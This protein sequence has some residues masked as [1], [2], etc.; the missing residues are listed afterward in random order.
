MARFASRHLV[1]AGLLVMGAVAFADAPVPAQ[2]EVVK[3][4]A[5]LLSQGDHLAIRE[6]L[7]PE[8]VFAV[9]DL[10]WSVA[11]G[12]AVSAQVRAMV[13]AGVRLEVELEAFA[14]DGTVLV[15]RERMWG[16]EV[17]ESLAPLRSTG[18]YVMDGEQIL[19]IT[20]VLDGDQ[21]DVLMREAIIGRWTGLRAFRFD[22]D[23]T[24]LSSTTV[25]TLDDA[26]DDVGHFVIEG[27]VMT[28]VS[29][30]ASDICDPG[31]VGTWRLRFDSADRLT[32]IAVEDTC[33]RRAMGPGT[34]LLIRA[35]D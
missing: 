31:D 16:D 20:R 13:A 9:H 12:P 19:S 2:F 1:V 26:P 18:V 32:W 21:R 24:A 5:A 8:R 34:M 15:T 29:D 7:A 25:T 27:G 28:V 22:A 4:F 17:P 33:A 30:D 6:V 23:G 10:Y 11:S 35:E 3:R 14:A